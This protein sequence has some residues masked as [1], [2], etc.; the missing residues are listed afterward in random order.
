MSADVVVMWVP[1]RFAA[2]VRGQDEARTH[3]VRTAFAAAALAPANLANAHRGRQRGEVTLAAPEGAR[4]CPEPTF[5]KGALNLRVTATGRSDVGPPSYAG[6]M[7]WLSR[8]R[9]SG[10]QRRLDSASRAYFS[11]RR[12]VQP[13][14]VDDAERDVGGRRAADRAA[15]RALYQLPEQRRQFPGHGHERVDRLVG[16]GRE[17][18]VGLEILAEPPCG[19]PG[20][21]IAW[22]AVYGIGPIVSTAGEPDARSALACSSPSSSRSFS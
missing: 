16:A 4:R 19:K 17:Q 14:R 13:R 6:L 21:S 15:V 2:D 3:T 18:P 5:V 22:S 12:E 10:S 11:R 7:F 8:N 20:S 1:F 9:L